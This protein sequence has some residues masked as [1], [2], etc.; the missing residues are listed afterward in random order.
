MVPP[1][2][3]VADAE[4]ASELAAGDASPPDAPEA[5]DAEPS[6]E[7]SGDLPADEVA[8]AEASGDIHTPKV[9]RRPTTPKYL[10]R[11]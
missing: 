8:D 1:A 3:E 9:V 7:G 2:D 10:G 6:D 5:D 4:A 11:E